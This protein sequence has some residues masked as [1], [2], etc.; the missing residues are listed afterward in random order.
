[1][2]SSLEKHSGRG[3]GSG[4]CLARSVVD[5]L[6]EE[7]ALEAVTIDRAQQ[8]ISVA[9]LGRVPQGG[10]GRLT[11]RIRAEF[12]AAQSVSAE[13]NCNL[14]TGQDDCR[15]CDQ[16]LSE[17]ER[18]KIT[19]QNEGPTTTIARVTC[20]TATTFW[21]WR[22]IPFPKVVQRDVEFL[23][24]AQEIDEWKPQLAA[25]ILCGVL[26]LAAHFLLTGQWS[27][28]AYV[29]AYLAGGFYPAKEVWEGL[30]KRTIDVHFLMIFVAAGAAGIGAWAEG[31]TLLFLFSFSGALE[32]YAL[33]RTQKEIRSLFRDAPKVATALDAQ[34][35]EREVKVEQLT[36]GM[37]LLIRPGAQFPVDAEIAKGSTA[38]DES[39][40]TGEATPVGKN[41]GDIALAGTINLWGAVEVVVVRP[42]AESSLQKIITLIKN[43]QQQKAPAQQFTDKVS[44]YYTYAALGLSFAMFFVWWLGFR[45]APFESAIESHSAFYRTMTLLV[46][47]SPCALVL[48]IPSAV[49]AAIAWGARHG[50][51][52][53]GGAAVEK[54]AEVNV[55]ALDKTGTLT[56]GELRVEK[57]ES[58]PPGREAEIARLAYS[59]EKL[60]THP[61]ARA[62]TR[63]GKQQQL[64]PV[65]FEQ[66]ESVT[67]EGLRAKWNGAIC[68]LGGRDWVLERRLPA[69]RDAVS[70]P[71][72]QC[73]GPGQLSL[74]SFGAAGAGAPVAAG[75]SEVWIETG[76]LLGRVIL[77]DDI[78]PQAA[79]VV[80]ELRREGLRTVVLTGDRQATAEHLRDKLK[81]DD[82]RAEL[83]PEQKVEAVRELSGQ[84]RKVAMIGDGVNDAPSLA[85]A[86]IGVAMGARGSDAALEQADVVLMHDRLENF[87]AAFR[88]SQRARLI[89]RQNLVISL[90]TVV[91]LVSF[92]LL[93]KIPLTIGVVGHEGSTVVVVMNSLRLLFGGHKQDA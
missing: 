45:L 66:F 24:H 29:F 10:I 60:S 23:E 80:E 78:R 49:L 32:H 68:S 33:G 82:V 90:G 35:R 6:A 91:V 87:L 1:M 26:G 28:A 84:G 81:L 59:L 39:N 11:E 19:I 48:S 53:R 47:A 62:I 36:R 17:T 71:A 57:V 43:A 54:L 93:G 40:L 38:A 31:A 51:L 76:D 12:E 50:I 85:A 58:F 14:L 25:A 89:I 69:R 18:E 2:N 64:E 52:F 20:P 4:Q 30:Q 92:A 86:H 61:L 79:S 65:V 70:N 67:G 77:R 63:H 3:S 73:A 74:G 27:V 41:I 16:P 9:T 7:P 55:V 34:G 22:D 42:A 88:L 13:R 15:S 75:F 21:R 37:R 72:V 5:T 44:T 56:T 46:V 83:K 8:K